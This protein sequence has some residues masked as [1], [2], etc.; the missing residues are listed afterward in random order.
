MHSQSRNTVYCS[1][2]A[3]GSIG[4]IRFL[5]YLSYYQIIIS[6]FFKL[7]ELLYNLSNCLLATAEVP[8]GVQVPLAKHCVQPPYHLTVGAVIVTDLSLKLHFGAQK[9]LCATLNRKKNLQF[10]VL[11]SYRIRYEV[12]TSRLQSA[13]T[14]CD[15]V[16]RQHGWKTQPRRK[17]IPVSLS[18]HL[19]FPLLCHFQMLLTNS[20]IY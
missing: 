14:K 18:L 15:H 13:G 8:N 19:A 20:P 3:A 1:G 16:R 17:N 10:T 4:G 2:V 5:S 12:T 11:G 9:F 7:G 6:I